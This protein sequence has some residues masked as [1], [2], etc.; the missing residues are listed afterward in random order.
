VNSPDPFVQ[1]IDAAWRASA[2]A[3]EPC[4]PEACCPAPAPAPTTIE[5]DAVLLEF[6]VARIGGTKGLATSNTARF[7]RSAG[8]TV[9]LDIATG[10]VHIGHKNGGAIIVPRERVKYFEPIDAA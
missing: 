1:A 5:F 4:C 3:P 9:T 8:N 2:P 10:L 6:E 7:S